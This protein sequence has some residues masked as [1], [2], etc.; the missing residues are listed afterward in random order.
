MKTRLVTLCTGY[1]D[2][3]GESYGLGDAWGWGY[4]D[5]SFVEYYLIAKF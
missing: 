5:G 2:G 4:G 3:S 1:G